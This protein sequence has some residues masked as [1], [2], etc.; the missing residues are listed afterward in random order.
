MSFF[1]SLQGRTP[2]TSDASRRKTRALKH[3]RSPAARSLPRTLTETSPWRPL[4]DSSIQYWRRPHSGAV[5]KYACSCTIIRQKRPSYC[6]LATE[7]ASKRA[8]GNEADKDTMLD[9]NRAAGNETYIALQRASSWPLG[10]FRRRSSRGSFVSDL[11]C[12]L[13]V[14]F[15]VSAFGNLN[16]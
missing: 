14:G 9:G 2:S 15:G 13:C 4:N 16:A 5:G 10:V 8:A 11:A 6:P 1:V 12:L 7:Q 3:N